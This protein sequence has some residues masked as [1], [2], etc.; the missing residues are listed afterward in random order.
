MERVAGTKTAGREVGGRQE[1]EML[2][3]SGEGTS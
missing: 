2:G 3:G 1:G